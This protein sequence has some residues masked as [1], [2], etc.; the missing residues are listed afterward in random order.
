GEK[1]DELR[2]EGWKTLKIGIGRSTA[3]VEAFLNRRL[4]AVMVPEPSGEAPPKARVAKDWQEMRKK[5]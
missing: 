1:L 5:L 2:A 3:F 4:Q